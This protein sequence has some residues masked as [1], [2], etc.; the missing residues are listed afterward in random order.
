MNFVD[1]DTGEDVPF[2]VY[3]EGQIRRA[4]VECPCGL[5]WSEPMTTI[6]T[7]GFTPCRKCGRFIQLTE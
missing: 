7:T 2:T 3:G 5:A 6:R 4:K 1:P